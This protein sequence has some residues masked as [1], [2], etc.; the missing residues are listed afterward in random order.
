MYK[1]IEP[2]IA[3]ICKKNIFPSHFPEGDFTRHPRY[4]AQ[5]LSGFVLGISG[6]NFT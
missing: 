1:I 4:K 2:R 5:N 6:D 3:T